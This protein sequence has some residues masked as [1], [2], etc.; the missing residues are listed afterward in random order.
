MLWAPGNRKPVSDLA[1][2]VHIISNDFNP[3]AGLASGGLAQ[4]ITMT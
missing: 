2:K 1:T 4:E 3:E